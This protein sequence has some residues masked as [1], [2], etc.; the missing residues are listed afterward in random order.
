MFVQLIE[1]QIDLT[2]EEIEA[3]QGG[4]EE[5]EEGKAFQEVST[6]K[7]AKKNKGKKQ[8]VNFKGDF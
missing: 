5:F 7:I 2:I 8:R 3:K 1:R 4:K 6:R